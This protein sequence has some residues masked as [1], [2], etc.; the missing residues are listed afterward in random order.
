MKIEPIEHMEEAVLKASSR[1]NRFFR[2][3]VPLAIGS[4]VVLSV[5]LG[6]ELYF[7]ASSEGF[8]NKVRRRLAVTIENAVGGRVEIGSFRWRLL[9]LEAEAGGIVIH[10][11]EAANEAPYA[12]IE[13][14]RV[15][16]SILGILSPSVRLSELEVTQPAL[17]LI[18]YANG[19]TNQPQPRVKVKSKQT[20]MER[21]F[22]MKAGRVAVENGSIHIDNRAAEFDFQD[23]HIPLDFA[24]D[25]VKVELSYVAATAH[26][27][28]S[29]RI[30]AGATDLTLARGAGREREPAM[31]GSVDVTLDLTRSSLELRE[32]KLSSRGNAGKHTLVT[33][34]TLEDFAHPRW[35]A[36]Q[37][38]E[39]DM[40][41]L[42]PALGYP[43][44]PEGIAHLDLAA[45]GTAADFKIDGGVHVDGGAYI[46]TGVIARGITLDCRVHADEDRLL[47]EQISVKL[48]PGGEIAGTVDLRHWL[49][50]SA[51]APRVVPAAYRPIRGSAGLSVET[52]DTTIP[53]DGKVTAEFR[54]VALDTL[55]DMVSVPPF[56]RLGIGALL[57]GPARADWSNGENNTVVVSTSLALSP[58]NGMPDETP[59]SG[60]VDATYTH[61]DGSVEV[62]K[63]SLAMP[64]STF[65]ATGKL[66][67]YPMTTAT[68]LNVS[69]HSRRIE[70]FDT[71]LRD[72]GL[73]RAARTG[74]SALPARLSGQTDFTGTWTGSLLKPRIAGTAKATALA[75]E[76]Q[77]S[78]SGQR[79]LD[80]DSA[81][82]AGSYSSERIAID[83]AT[84][85]HGAARLTV[86]GTL[87]A[88]L[89]TV[90]GAPVHFY[91]R[92]SV[93]HVK[94]AAS[95]VGIAEIGAFTGS[96]LPATGTIDAGFE[97]HGPVSAPSGSGWAELDH[98]SVLGQPIDRV[99]A[100]GTLNGSTLE[101]ADVTSSLAGGSIA[102]KGKYDF[103]TGRYELNGES[104]NVELGKLD[105]VQQHGVALSGKL[106]ASLSGTGTSG[107]PRLDGRA[108]V[109]GLVVNG[110]PLGSLSATAHTASRA[111]TY[112]VAT[113]LEGA[114]LKLVGQTSLDGDNDTQN[115][116]EFTRL[117]VGKLLKV[118]HVG[119][120][121][122]ESALAGTATLS[123]PL[124]RPENLRGE[125][126]IEQL[127]MTLA[128]IHMGGEGGAHAALA[129]GVVR[130]DP[131]HITGLNTD[132]R[133]SATVALTGDHRVDAAASGTID[134][135]VAETIDPD[136]TASGATTFNVEAHGTFEH[137]GLRGR[138]EVANGAMA[139]G[140]LSNGLSQMNGTL[141]FNQDRLEVRS[142]TAMTGGGLLTVGGSL[143]YQHGLYADLTVTGKGV[144]IRYPEGVSSLADASLRLVGPQANLL[145]SGDV[146]VT[147]FAVSPELDLAALATRSGQ[148][149]ASIAP[150]SAP[151]NRVRLDIHLASS[152]Q[153][154]FQNSLAKLA[155]N[156]DLR[157]RGTV[158][159]P[160]VLGRISV[161]EGSAT[162][163]GTRY[164][165][166]RGDI[167]M[168][169]PVRIQ[170]VIDLTATAH[171]QDYDITLGL[172]GPPEKLTV[173]YR[174]DPPLP[175]TDVVSLLALGHTGSQQRLYTQQ[176][177]Q[178][179][180]SPS[181]DKLLGGA[182]NATMSSRMQK[183]FGSGS[184]KV[185]P[186]YLG[187]FGN[188]T[189][190]VTVQEQLGRVLTLTYATDV[191][192]TSQQLL[193]ADVAINRHVSLVVARDESGV[194][195]MVLK[196]TRRFK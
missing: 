41:V 29:Y 54:N 194:F 13:H 68:A 18:V 184:V 2:R 53:V 64:L 178:E 176:Q 56:T 98:G 154:N 131:V 136:V 14:L 148:Q 195:S 116:L 34:G 137:P 132:L 164:D 192:T 97:A 155:G 78:G 129:D 123:G 188:S 89:E 77:G 19:E 84:V 71:V 156:V 103:S 168:T 21:L 193:E 115:R 99:H 92:N 191:N 30:E 42:E 163:A 83:H 9:S 86:S 114:E 175:E 161:T 150:A 166:E 67:A 36:K 135:K 72:L 183:L 88:A 94:V 87:D 40:G 143:T 58:W 90:R 119:G 171:V 185:D 5:L 102:G 43:F 65:E 52:A 177:E 55:L 126:H 170:P 39:L 139:L 75:V 100:Q 130:L 141:E 186:H 146:L 117:D 110:E 59:A 106:S 167:T 124:T 162:I 142:L 189:S 31:H 46:G 79:F 165:L 133:A 8:Q 127:A 187:A 180:F 174:S 147:R 24:A 120:I 57:N 22:D 118:M 44:A 104:R 82:A 51:S 50:P 28:E 179:A 128:G 173:S 62:R 196:A 48:K 138:V 23:R 108:T 27:P 11:R 144:R 149:T 6:L 91:N 26:A 121:S 101:L 12:R 20:P 76:M 145:L 37:Q 111:A 172:H 158:A 33:S 4:I 66:G 159:S 47:I 109:S 160:S 152:P 45:H 153:L 122:G 1:V 95:K 70:E 112:T 85:T 7:Y 125:A 63:L 49:L 17:H 15:K 190:R 96:T 60:A 107:D 134:L 73:E 140:D 10:G 181:T 74:A 35:Q 105:W 61:R 157:I 3:H 169:N 69:L 81:E 32:L 182:L 38:G 113:A 16:A 25:K 93:L 80:L 151:S